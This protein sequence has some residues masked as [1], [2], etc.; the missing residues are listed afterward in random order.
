MDRRAGLNPNAKTND[1]SQQF[2]PLFHTLRFCQESLN[3]GGEESRVQGSCGVEFKDK[4]KIFET[5]AQ[6]PP[7]S[8]TNKIKKGAVDVMRTILYLCAFFPQNLNPVMRKTSN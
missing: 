1:S 6:P 2:S 5:T 3:I 8:K 7:S 4:T